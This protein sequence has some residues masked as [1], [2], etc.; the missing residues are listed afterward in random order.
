MIAARYLAEV[1]GRSSFGTVKKTASGRHRAF[2]TV[3]GVTHSA[4]R[5]FPNKARADS[6]LKSEWDRR[7]S[8]TWVERRPSTT[9]RSFVDEQWWPWMTHLAE[10]TADDY[11]QVLQTWIYRTFDRPGRSSVSL[12]EIP[13]AEI[14]E[15]DVRAWYAASKTRGRDARLAKAYRLLG[16]VMRAA[17]ERGA[18]ARSPVRIKGAGTEVAPERPVLTV[19]E[20][21]A[22]ARAMEP[23]YQAMVLLAAFG[24]L[25]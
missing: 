17:E 6:W 19:D 13:I 7:R 20:L 11:R 18:I 16:E 4:G 12:A 8:G 2:Y 15:D 23:R 24:A 5:T 14:T 25:R 1:A 9:L 21:V 22:L 3:S 10:R